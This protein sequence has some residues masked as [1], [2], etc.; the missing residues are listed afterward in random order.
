[1]GVKRA[2]VIKVIPHIAIDRRVANGKN[3]I[4]FNGRATCSGLQASRTSVIT[5]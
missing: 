2:L 1:M 4:E 5:I 3:A